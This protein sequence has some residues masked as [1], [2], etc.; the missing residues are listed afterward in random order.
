MIACGLKW[1]PAPRSVLHWSPTRGRASLCRAIRI[2]T[3]SQISAGGPPAEKEKGCAR[4]FHE[5]AFGLYIDLGL[6]TQPGLTA[7]CFPAPLKFLD[8][9]R[10]RPDKGFIKAALGAEYLIGRHLSSELV[11]ELTGAGRNLLRSAR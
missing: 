4:R 1:R 10:M 11:F 6:Q 5:A 3:T 7:D 8:G 9:V 2:G